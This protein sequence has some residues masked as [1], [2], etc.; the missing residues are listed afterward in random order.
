[1]KLTFLGGA[2]EVGASSTLV[3]IAGHRLLVDC[4]IRMQDRSGDQLPWLAHLQ[5]VGGI[6][7]IILTHAHMDH[8]GALPVVCS[9][10]K[11]PLYLTSPTLALITILL[12]DAV[13]I[14]ALE[15]ERE[16]EMPLYSLPMVENVMGAAR[17]V[18]FLQPVSLFGG[19]VKVTYYPAGHILGAGSVVIESEKDGT[20][21]ITGDIAATNQLTVPGLMIPP[22]KPDAVV[23]ES[24]Y[25]GRLHANRAAE[26]K[27]LI[28]QAQDVI[29]RGGQMLIPAFA[30]GRAQEVIL[31]LSRAMEENKLTRVPIFI[32]GMVRQVCG[33]YASF[34][35]LV[36]PWLRS[37]IKKLGRPF[38][39]EDGPAVP[40]W[41][42]KNREECLKIKPS[43]FISSSGMLSGGPSQ[44]YAIK[45]ANDKKN[46]IAITGYQDEES[47]GRKV[48]DLARE[49]GGELTI[50]LDRIQLNCGVGTY[51][52]SAHSDSS[53]I[54]AE[55]QAL[56]PKNVILVHGNLEAR[57]AI[58]QMAK[59]SGFKSVLLPDLTTEI[60]IK[61]R[62]KRAK[63][64]VTKGEIQADVPELNLENLAE[65]AQKI[66][67]RDGPG[68]LY[69]VQEIL[70]SW[71]QAAE[72]I[73]QEEITRVSEILSHK[74][75]PFSRDRKRQFIFRLRTSGK[76]I[77]NLAKIAKQ[78]PKIGIDSTTALNKV[79]AL[80]PLETGLYHKGAKVDEKIITLSFHFPKIAST[81]YEEL[82]KEAE[83]QTGWKIQ[84]E[85]KVHQ[86]ALSEAA[87][88]LLPEG[89]EIRKR[90]SI[91]L[92]EEYV[93]V[94]V[95]GKIPDNFEELSNTLY[96]KTGFKIVFKGTLP[97]LI[98]TQNT[99]SP[100]EP[101]APDAVKME[102]NAS[103][104]LIKE[105]FSSLAHKPFK[106]SLKGGNI[107]I[108]FI[109]PKIGERYINIINELER[110]IGWPIS[111]RQ[112]PDQ[113]QLQS[114][115]KSLISAKWKL[116]KEPS[117]I[118][119]N[120]SISV[121]LVSKPSLEEMNEL[122]EQFSDL[123]GCLL[124][125]A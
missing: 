70:S 115:A 79:G 94:H 18:P 96:Q 52:L 22:V 36:T 120:H 45:M 81:L 56:N 64:D 75:S 35:E 104:A 86:E 82:I 48:Q 42:P 2:D 87:L 14:M 123:T 33:V 122:V 77:L 38:F 37:R 39:Y 105:A 111:I 12:L 26:E 112:Q 90:P 71:G 49:G 21:M 6:E 83:E 101:L 80:F 117:F 11:V 4:G 125:F 78:T 124:V 103:Y 63:K 43:I 89:V 57:Q 102:I 40:I 9:T 61:T 88:A 46:F 95:E 119:Q 31:I 118:P 28:E 41:D 69:T 17:T 44:Y 74:K 65:L 54:L 97:S 47:P 91:H 16:G 99:S 1:M 24:T 60:E 114:I 29:N 93:T 108:A 32:D 84:V 116:L 67:D 8:S 34:P 10:Y 30:V 98:T 55:L 110:K 66:L 72:N 25:G 73:T 7:A 19:E 5:E 76:E 100:S 20:V 106:T 51:S 85:S 92:V 50:G 23:I 62:A 113:M 107:E 121:K 3:E 27:R 13:K 58:A 59:D 109:S 53:Q 15:Q 68:R